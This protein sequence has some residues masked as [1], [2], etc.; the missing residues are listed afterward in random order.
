MIDTTFAAYDLYSR[1]S[2]NEDGFVHVLSGD[3]QVY[4][5]KTS[6]TCNGKTAL[7]D[8][9][10]YSTV[11]LNGIY[12]QRPHPDEELYRSLAFKKNVP[13]DSFLVA[14]T[15]SV[16]LDIEELLALDR[17]ISLSVQECF[18]Q[19]CF[20]TGGGD[21]ATQ[22][23]VD[24]TM[25]KSSC[26]QH[27]V[28]LT[29]SRMELLSLC[30]LQ[31]AACE[32]PQGVNISEIS[33]AMCQK[34]LRWT[35]EDEHTSHFIFSKNALY[36]L[37]QCNSG[38][39]STLSVQHHCLSLT[40]THPV[41]ARLTFWRRE[42]SISQK[43]QF[44]KT[45]TRHGMADWTVPRQR[46]SGELVEDF[47]VAERLFWP[48]ID[49]LVKAYQVPCKMTDVKDSD[50]SLDISD[51]HREQSG[52]LLDR[53]RPKERPVVSLRMVRAYAKGVFQT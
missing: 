33:T 6:I 18:Q 29:G 52:F 20:E 36:L 11:G 1:I 49:H 32:I 44:V 3:V 22:V 41:K 45:A 53:R 12:P 39:L 37:Q 4:A 10:V 2:Q 27:N 47:G 35:F 28:L 25:T 21:S 34:T 19:K 38:K 40:I 24:L 48:A 15:S 42:R 31:G 8:V 50:E 16:F 46:C 51:V 13:T 26:G 17:K 43:V 7:Q 5:S 30:L 23:V 14:Y 9:L